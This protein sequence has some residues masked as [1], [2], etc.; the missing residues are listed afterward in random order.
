M[1]TWCR[2]FF[3]ARP[4][5]LIRPALAL[6]LLVHVASFSAAAQGT[7]LELIEALPDTDTLYPGDVFF[8]RYRVR[9][10]NPPQFG[11]VKML[12]ESEGADFIAPA[13]SGETPGFT[14]TAENGALNWNSD[15]IGTSSLPL[16]IPAVSCEFGGFCPSEPQTL[17]QSLLQ[18]PTALGV[19][20]IAIE[21]TFNSD[22]SVTETEVARLLVKI[23]EVE[24]PSPLSLGAIKNQPL[25]TRQ[26]V[27]VNVPGARFDE[28]E[29]ITVHLLRSNDIDLRRSALFFPGGDSPCPEQPLSNNFGMCGLEVVDAQKVAFSIDAFFDE[30]QAQAQNILGTYDIY[31]RWT[32]GTQVEGIFRTLESVGL[33]VWTIG[34]GSEG[35]D[36]SVRHIEVNQAV[37]TD[38][39]MIPMVADKRTV[40]RVYPQVENLPEGQLF[41]P[42]VAVNL[43]GQAGQD[44]P[45]LGE[46]TEFPWAILG[47]DARLGTLRNRLD[48]SADFVLPREW[49]QVEDLFLTATVNLDESGDPLA[50]ETST[51]NNTKSESFPFSRRKTLAIGYLEACPDGCDN[52]VHNADR[53]LRKVF[54]AA[55]TSGVA[56]IPLGVP[57]GLFGDPISG[58]TLAGVLNGF[59]AVLFLQRD[60]VD[61]VVV[62]ARPVGSD[63][64]EEELAR[65]I[66]L[67]K[68]LKAVFGTFVVPEGP[69]EKSEIELPLAIA[70]ELE[71]FKESDFQFVDT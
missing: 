35:L 67:R 7:S 2:P 39:N 12:V 61:M 69:R 32:P 62:W 51:D 9:V 59:K 55:E 18:I 56:Y 34:E 57:E 26:K 13:T 71:I 19:T 28:A 3:A 8:A 58:F 4:P 33:G 54:P 10:V 24:E 68:P 1:L 64:T 14:S 30:A 36:Y 66:L 5:S 44:G 37:Q 29:G 17:E 20:A 41:G 46:M 47:P 22:G 43:Q 16:S 50:E 63:P 15:D 27:F 70:K 45:M 21:R 60:I 40:A 38:D 23:Y 53:F 48:L 49:T 31:V 6:L 52:G 25:N 65:E 11:G 42:S